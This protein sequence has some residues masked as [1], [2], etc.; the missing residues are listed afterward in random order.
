M[1]QGIARREFLKSGSVAAALLALHP[2][3]LFAASNSSAVL[4]VG[5][6]D[7]VPAPGEG[8]RLIGAER[9]LSGDPAF[10]SRGARVTIGSFHR[11]PKYDGRP[12]GAAIAAIFPVLSYA[13]ESY[14]R[15]NAW[16]FDGRTADSGRRPVRFSMPVTATQ[17]VQFAVQRNLLPLTLGSDSSALKLQ[18]GVYVIA[19]R[20]SAA[21][22]PPPWSALTLGNAADG[23]A[24]DSTAFSYVVITLDFAD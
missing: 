7:R 14:P 6:A 16:I 2:V 10:I 21:D 8:V 12:G 3:S 5:F 13:P 4:S 19:L 22:S 20:E 23:L 24:V 11:A 1:S 15:F 18:R 9:V 17:G